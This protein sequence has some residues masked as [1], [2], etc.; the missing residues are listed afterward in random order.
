MVTGASTLKS[1]TLP[2]TNS[3]L[4]DQK[5]RE[6]HSSFRQTT[7]FICGIA[8]KGTSISAIGLNNVTP[9]RIHGSSPRPPRNGD[10]QKHGFASER[11]GAEL[12]IPLRYQNYRTDPFRPLSWHYQRSQSLQVLPFLD[13]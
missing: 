6:E 8:T 11:F 3:K 2:V 5:R 4:L 12:T 1:T 10:V 9:D 7:R 13:F